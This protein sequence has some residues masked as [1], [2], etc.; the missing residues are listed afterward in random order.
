MDTMMEETRTKICSKCGIEK[1]LNE[2][3]R[4]SASKDGHQYQCRL[5]K[6]EYSFKTKKSNIDKVFTEDMTKI[7][8]VCF[9]EKFV[10]LF[11][12]ALHQGDGLSYQCKE[13]K[14]KYVKE[15]SERIK[16]SNYNYRQKRL[17]EYPDY[18]HQYYIK[19]RDAILS[20]KYKTYWENPDKYRLVGREHYQNNKESILLKEKEQ[21][22]SNPENTKERDRIFYL[23]RRERG[24][25]AQYY[26]ENKEHILAYTREYYRQDP[27]RKLVWTRNRQAIIAGA[28]IGHVPP[29]IK[30]ILRKEQEGMCGICNTLVLDGDSV[31]VDHIIPITRGGPH[32]VANLQYTHGS[33]NDQK[34]NKLPEE[35]GL[36]MP[37]RDIL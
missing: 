23:R 19:N 7:C 18:D 3:N 28:T 30:E 17:K 33:C 24:Y 5:C 14:A 1:L 35:C 32:T 34:N 10:F 4:M 8:P 26:R 21:R 13:C 36:I 27:E 16:L 31:H 2:F 11:S 29:D 22:I 15:N 25:F 37:I 12:K 6:K 9:E 20:R